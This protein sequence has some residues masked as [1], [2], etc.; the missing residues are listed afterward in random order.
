MSAD[1]F[2]D[3]VHRATFVSAKTCSGP[4]VVVEKDEAR[5]WLT[6]N[7]RSKQHG[8]ARFD[9]HALFLGCPEWEGEEVTP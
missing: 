7:L 8:R 9:G 1:D 3:A 6:N 5:R 2:V 4:Y